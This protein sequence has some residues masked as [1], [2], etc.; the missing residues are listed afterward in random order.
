MSHEIR[1]P[2]NGV[3][4]MTGLLLDTVLDQIQKEYV[5][6]IRLSGEQLLI[7]INDILDFSK[8]ESERLELENQPFDLREC[9]ED[10]LDLLA[11]KAAEKNIELV[12]SIDKHSPLAI[13][14]DITRLRQILTNLVSNSVKFTDQGEIYIAVTSKKLDHKKYEIQFAVKDTG[15]GIPPD[16]MDRLF[17]SFSQVDPSASR[18]YGGTGLG[19]V[20]SKRLAELMNGSMWVESEVDKGAI[21]YFN[22]VTEAISS[23]PKSSLYESLRIFL[24]KKIVVA[25]EN[26][27]CLNVTCNQLADWGMETVAI[28]SSAEL[29]EFIENNSSCDGIILDYKSDDPESEKLINYLKNIIKKTPVP[30]IITLPI[31]ATRDFLP[32]IDDEFISVYPKPVRRQYLHKAL[33]VRLSKLNGDVEEREV[34]TKSIEIAD[35]D[36]SSLKILLVEDNA[37][38]QK[39]A[40]RLIEKLGCRTDLASDGIEAVEAVQLIDYDIVFM[41]LLMPEMDGLEATKQIK[42]LAANKARPKIIAMTANSMLG[43]RE[44]CIDAGMDDYI[45]KP[46]RIDELNAALDKWLVVVEEEREQHLAEL[47]EHK[48]ETEILKENDIT[49]LNDIQNQ[50]DLE[51][52]IDLIDIYLKDLLV[53]IDEITV[54]VENDNFEKLKFY[55]HKLKGSTLTLGIE[56]ISEYCY[57][58]EKAADD[59]IID[60]YIILQNRVLKS[61]IRK[62]ISE[63][64]LLKEKYLNF[65]F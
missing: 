11:P 58:L 40:S 10:S 38:N 62:V 29:I 27:T 63:L 2:M 21:F 41:D 57:D 43:D 7:I 50:E 5:N 46:I 18:S 9:I 1:T 52:F 65:N 44:L 53:I 34:A 14:G 48:I 23:D 22:I 15:I 39:V 4:G 24:A 32:D 56:S 61:Y 17:K 16:K 60:E 64:K 26:N 6:T 30:I 28:N 55:T 45:N 19:L 54:A 8:I 47:K 13:N 36:K 20:I 49:F 31:G 25:L 3:I 51:F 42:E 33:S 35:K 37:V 59:K 12:Y